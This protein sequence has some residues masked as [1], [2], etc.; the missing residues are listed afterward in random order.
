M[1]ILV[2]TLGETIDATALCIKMLAWGLLLI[3]GA[4]PWLEASEQ[5]CERRSQDSFYNYGSMCLPIAVWYNVWNV[6]A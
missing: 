3:G 1:I 4:R 5:R 6:W 2:G